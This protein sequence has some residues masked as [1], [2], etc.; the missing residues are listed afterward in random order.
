MKDIVERL[1]GSTGRDSQPAS[2]SNEGMS[3]LAEDQDCLDDFQ[4][5]S[6]TY[7]RVGSPNTVEGVF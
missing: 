2:T 6:P 4:Q 5:R 7:G 3:L 1:G